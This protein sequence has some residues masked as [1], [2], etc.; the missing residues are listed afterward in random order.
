MWVSKN[1][2]N[3]TQ[4]HLNNCPKKFNKL[5][6]GLRFLSPAFWLVSGHKNWESSMVTSVS[7]YSAEENHQQPLPRSSRVFLVIFSFPPLEVGY[8][9]SGAAGQRGSLVVLAMV[10]SLFLSLSRSLSQTVASRGFSSGALRKLWRLKE[11]LR[12]GD[13]EAQKWD[14][15]ND[16]GTTVKH[17]SYVLNAWKKKS[18][19]FK[20]I[21]CI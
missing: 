17:F 16:E 13:V 15:K 9:G 12:E 18:V 10:R 14:K 4:K 2:G 11:S 6:S 7:S 1:K 21:R 19:K 3:Q 8:W 20:K 5:N